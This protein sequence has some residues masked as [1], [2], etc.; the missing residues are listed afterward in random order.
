MQSIQLREQ[1]V[2]FMGQRECG[3]TL[4]RMWELTEHMFGSKPRSLFWIT[5]TLV[6]I[7]HSVVTL[8]GI[9]S[10]LM[11]IFVLEVKCCRLELGV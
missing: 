1:Q 7:G 9:V 3:L 8:T 6:M 5:V 4:M 2:G 10:V 11:M